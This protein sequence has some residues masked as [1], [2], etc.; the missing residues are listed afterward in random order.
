VVFYESLDK[1]M[2][3]LWVDWEDNSSNL[4]GRGCGVYEGFRLSLSSNQDTLRM[5]FRDS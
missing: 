3:E 5:P 1:K 2:V 4:Q